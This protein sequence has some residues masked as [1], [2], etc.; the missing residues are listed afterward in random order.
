MVRPGVSVITRAT[1]PA[2]TLRSS[3]GTAFMAQICAEGPAN[4]PVLCLNIGDWTKVFGQRESTTPAYDSVETFF[5]EG[6]SRLYFSRV[7]GPA[8]VT[9]FLNLVDR[10]G[11]PLPTLK[12]SAIG[13]GAYGTQISVQIANGVGANTFVVIIT[14]NAIE[15]ERSGDLANPTDAVNWSTGSSYVRITDLASATVAPNNNPAV[16][17]ATPLGGAATDDRAN[18]VDA[19]KI[20]AINAFGPEFG[21]GQLLYPGATTATI[22]AALGAA[23]KLTNRQALC[24]LPDS[25]VKATLT[26][27]L[28]GV[29]D[30]Y[31]A[32]FGP[33]VKVPGLLPGTTRIVP[34]SAFVAG[35]IARAE[36]Q[37]VSP[38]RPAA[39]SR[40]RAQFAIG[41]TQVYTDADREALNTAGID[42]IRMVNN[43][44]TL[45]GYRTAASPTINSQ[46]VGLGNQRLRLSI[47]EEVLDLAEEFQFG[48]I[49]G[50]G[51]FF[52]EVGGAVDGVLRTWYD[53]GSL[54][55]ATPDDAYFTDTGPAVN[56]P[57]TIQNNE[58]HVVVSAKMSQF[59]EMSVFEIVKLGLT[60]PI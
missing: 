21:T 31:R 27:I 9:A 35:I 33:W 48:E 37:G 28:A 50:Q 6:G 53:K 45:Y 16:L 40:G 1:P 20:A 52:S 8:P 13:P 4:T 12:V 7:V 30:E 38:N 22:H 47:T 15:V 49:D 42:I 29:N 5:R 54:Y 25:G 32:Y 41:V 19:Q 26:A 46:W 23:G 18:A 3:R 56:T 34:Q 55:G 11:V 24:D 36:S 57:Q 60:D 51:L 17:A 58:L 39:G 10:A 59:A 43:V 44:V 2:R 14:R